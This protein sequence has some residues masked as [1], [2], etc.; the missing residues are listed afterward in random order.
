MKIIIPMAGMGTR[1]RPHTL[2]VP[3][4]LIV[5]A[6]KSIVQRL[7]ES[8]T[9][10]YSEPVEEIGFVIGDF[11]EK[12]EKSLIDIAE[13]VGAKAKIYYQHQALG[14]AHAV[15]CAG[16]SLSGK[17]V[18]AFADTLFF[19]DFKINNDSDSIIWV[20]KVTNPQAY[21]VVTTDKSGLITGFVEKPANF[22]SDLAIIGIY[23]FKDGEKL[24]K[25]LNNIID[26]KIMKSG[27]YQLTTALENLRSQGLKF[28]PG[29]VDEWL[30]CGN[31]EI[32]VA[33]HQRILAKSTDAKY[34]SKTAKIENST[35]I[36]PCFIGNNTIISES[37]IGPYVSIGEN[38]VIKNSVISNSIIQNSSKIENICAHDSMIGNNTKISGK[39]FDLSV[40]DY[41]IIDLK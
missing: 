5:L 36:Q 30:D 20:H 21:G 33:T 2:T 24:K 31:K 3:K 1:M 37:V 27:E 35:I 26:N 14:T 4:P 10:V 22:V 12:V 6:G 41:N 40:G 32:T 39:P 34:L 13:N 23:Y 18:V 17:T 29:E 16:D 8:I 9:K 19:A 38:S 28:A 15:W 7:V 11:G 25:E